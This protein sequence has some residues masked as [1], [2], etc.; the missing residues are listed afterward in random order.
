MTTNYDNNNNNNNNYIVFIST[1]E[2]GLGLLF[3][4]K[5]ICMKLIKKELL[6]ITRLLINS[7]K[8]LYMTVDI[9]G[10]WLI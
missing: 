9:D 4:A 3:V 2:R 8:H 1:V 5:T 7:I 6:L 10:I